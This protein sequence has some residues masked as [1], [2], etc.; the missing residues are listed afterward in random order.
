MTFR[1]LSIDGGGMRGLYA[2]T[3][4][5]RLEHAF[6]SRRQISDGLDVGKAFDLIVGTSTGAIIGCGL[7]YGLSAKN[8]TDLYRTHGADIFPKKMPA[9]FGPD[10]LFQ[11]HS[12]PCHLAN[13]AAA[14]RGALEKAFPETTIK[15]L[16]DTRGIALAVPA[17]RMGNYQSWVFKTP[18]DS[19]SNHRDDHYSLADVCMASSAAP[20][21]RSLE[22]L[23]SPSGHGYDVFADGGLWANN[24]VIVALVEA[25]RMTLDRGI[26]DDIEI[27]CLGSC[28]KPEGV[29]VIKDQVNR[30]LMEWK[31]GGE[32]ASLSIAAQE[33]AFDY[34]AHMLLPHLKQKVSIAR[35]PSNKIPAALLKYLDLD[36]TSQSGMDALAAQARA[37]AD[38]TNSATQ[39]GT[40]D[41]QLI[42]NLFNS[43]PARASTT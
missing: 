3:Y 39:R 15:T 42:E 5:D 9:S 41:G 33:S 31:F 18:H 8:I 12:R 13:G 36:E 22:A 6:S 10:L 23:D 26:E 20:L 11:L 14:L 35:F 7:A 40:P 27:Y 4:L 29:E 21:F 24:P 37:D 19:K 28:G 2:A 43:M 16:W 17:V 38:F 32:A 34:I 25:L 30:G 1:V